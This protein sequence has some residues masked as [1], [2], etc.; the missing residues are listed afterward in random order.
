MEHKREP[1]TDR[2]DIAP[3][4]PLP[5]G[6]VTLADHWAAWRAGA[7]GPH[8]TGFVWQLVPAAAGSEPRGRQLM[9]GDL[10]LDGQRLVMDD[11]DP[12]GIIPPTS[13][14][15]DALHRFDWLDDLAA[16][17]SDAGRATAQAWLSGW[18]ARH[19]RGSG[20]GWRVDLVGPRQMQLIAHAGFVLPGLAP[21]DRTRLFSALSRQAG[22]LQG[23]W[24]QAPRGPARFLALASLV[25][26][27]CALSG[28][29]STLRPALTALA[30]ECAQD[31][32]AAGGIITRTPEHL[33]AVFDL[34]TRIAAC[35]RQAGKP[36]D[37]AI[38]TAIARIAPT[39]RSLR[40]A[41]GTLARMQ[42]GGRGAP[43]LLET[44]LARANLRPAR[45]RGLAMGYAR[46]GGGQVSL[47]VDAA[48]PLLGQGSCDAHA[49]SLAFE[50]VAGKEPVI[51][52][53]GSGRRFGPQWRRA[54]RATANHSTLALMGYAS[55][56]LARGASHAD[57][58]PQEF[59]TGPSTVEVQ[60]SEMKT[61]EGLALSHDGWRATH[62]LVHLRS[63]Q[64]DHDG[65]L[66]RGE[67]G[68][69]AMTEA[70]RATLDRVLARLPREQGLVYAVRF[71]VH[72][73][74]VARIDMG[75]TAVS[76][77]LPSRETWVFRHAGDAV[78]TLEPSVYLDST[79][80][81]PRA[82]KQIVLTGRLTGYGSAVSWSLAR[83][84]GL[85]AAPGG[86][87][88]EH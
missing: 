85:L 77:T 31:I 34:L 83:P 26:S 87:G 63:L 50:L 48:P 22:F 69:A 65:T 61:A 16:V 56:R 75:G 14:F 81:R 54:G 8:I 86:L 52:S 10:L 37:P 4:P 30:Q 84:M 71:H 17:P 47:I 49:S 24:R 12:W 29:E 35:L 36:A 32:D 64:L 3:A 9:A 59:V 11:A 68:L 15:Q 2:P 45:I 7:F 28:M 13:G 74:A 40:H 27:A 62:G 79:Q 43:G 82:T 33:L 21:Q 67:D 44:A 19:R 80:P 78:L 72:P 51:V 70:D 38:D 1:M 42:G 58:A 46:L 5:I 18:L 66:L 73:D 41:D 20:P 57:T 23:R 60:H 76:I 53:A 25:T 88:H 6:R 55:A 39:L